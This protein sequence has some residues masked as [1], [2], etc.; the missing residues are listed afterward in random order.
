MD[1]G[2]LITKSNFKW[3]VFLNSIIKIQYIDDVIAKMEIHLE[4]N[5]FAGLLQFHHNKREF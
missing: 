5:F 2:N 1:Y 4:K 3:I